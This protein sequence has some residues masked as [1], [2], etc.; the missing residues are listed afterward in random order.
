MYAV[1]I[2]GKFRSDPCPK[3]KNGMCPKC[4]QKLDPGY[5]FGG[6]YGLGTY[7]FCHK[8]KKFFDFVEDKG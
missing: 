5:G 3:S 6:G 1:Y 8:C 4:G 2:D 7:N